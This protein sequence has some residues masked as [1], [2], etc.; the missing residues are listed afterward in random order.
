VANRS[1]FWI[2]ISLF[3]FGLIIGLIYLNGK[4]STAN[5]SKSIQGEKK[6]VKTDNKQKFEKRIVFIQPLSEVKPDYLRIIKESIESFYSFRCEVRK[7]A[8]L[9]ADLLAASKI[10][11]E[12]SKIL[13]RFNSKENLLLITEKDIACKKGEY[14]EWGILGLG[15]NPGKTCIIST[16]RMKRSVSED[17]VIDRLRKVVLH[18]LG[19]NLGLEHCDYHPE[20]LMNDAKGSIKQVD[21]EKIWL[22]YKCRSFIELKFP[23]DSI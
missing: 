11:Y 12:A 22:C 17:I 8:N 10:R 2:T 5:V 13:K 9:T 20:C 16:F 6:T 18:E 14:P 7:E 3:I 4:Y 15:Y 21:K 23:S 19:H 1:F